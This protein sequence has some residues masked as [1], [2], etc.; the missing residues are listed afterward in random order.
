MAR[1]KTALLIALASWGAVV[2]DDI[3]GAG[4]P[5]QVSMPAAAPV[6]P[7]GM[8]TAVPRY[9]YRVIRQWPHDPSAYTQGLLYAGG[10][11]LEGTG[12]NG[13]SSLRKVDLRT[14]AVLARREL[15]HQH[16]GE[17]IAVLR[18]RIYQLTWLSRK[19]FIYALTDLQ[20]LGEFSYQGQGWGL[21]TDGERLIMSD[22][23]AI[24]R[25]LDPETF[26]VSRILRVSDRGRPVYQLNE[27][28][29][30]NGEIFANVWRSDRIARI[31]PLSGR[32]TGWIELDGL[33]AAAG[34]FP[35]ADVL[36][37]IAYDGEGDRLF[38]TGKLWP[39][40]FEIRLIDRGPDG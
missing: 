3:D 11:L 13:R 6:A 4:G 7:A 30:V 1:R 25:Y 32:V 17:G 36:N 35:D 15:P 20:P 33:L 18:D 38:V 29:F 34:H 21:T 28:E 16:F 37:G 8:D 9:G 27:L 26:T 5:W 22:G 40:L 19:G 31:D 14:G 2:A 24:L 10:V 39:W 12:L 23:S